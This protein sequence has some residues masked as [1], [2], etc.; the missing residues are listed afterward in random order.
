MTELWVT[1]DARPDVTVLAVRGKI[2]FDTQQPLDQAVKRA[3]VESGPRIVVDMHEVTMCDSSG[4]QLLIDARRQAV[5]AGGWVRLCRP[6]ALVARVLEITNLS[7]LLSVF[8]S[9]DAA[10]SAPEPPGSDRF[11]DSQHRPGDL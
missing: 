10:V 4:L 6:Q 7:S 5:P 9:V 3:L 2:L 11:P 8:D 1:V